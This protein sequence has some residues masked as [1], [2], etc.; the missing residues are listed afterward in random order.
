MHVII[1][2]MASM[3]RLQVLAA[4][5]AALAAPARAT[6][7]PKTSKVTI[8]TDPPGA[9][10]YFGLK[11]D[12][13]VC[14][15]PCTID[16]P[17]G[18]T[19]II[20][21]AENRRSIIENLV[22]PKRTARPLRV[23]YK[24]EPAIGALIVEGGDGATI[25]ID[26][27]DAGTAPGRIDGLLAGPHHVVV[28]RAGKVI[29]DDFL[30]IEAG[31]ETTAAV[32]SGKGGGEPAPAPREPDEPA[33]TRLDRPSASPVRRAGASVA[34]GVALDVGFRQFTFRNNQTPRTQRDDREGGQLMAGP[35]VEVWP[36]RLLGSDRLRGLA[37]YGRFEFGVNSQAVTV[38]DSATGMKLPTTLST[39][40]RSL[41]ASVHQRWTV[42][43]TA[44]VEVG[45]GYVQDRFQFKG[46][47]AE[48]AVVPDA[49]YKAVRIGGRLALLLGELEP[50]LTFESRIVLS[51]G[52]LGERY[53]LGTS[54]SGLRGT[55]GAALHFGSLQVRVEGGLTRYSWA[56][57][58]DAGDLTKADGGTDAIENVQFVLCYAR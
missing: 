42:A 28:E 17:I 7:A 46:S 39:S 32:G 22:V 38:L 11:E 13:E 26:D 41:E 49:S 50:Y 53:T 48:L 19:P 20:V 24:L 12:G 23:R 55:L 10:V 44:T 6:A 52:A 37:L 5:A 3:G 27:D 58:P 47:A 1:A 29:Y 33:V 36:T 31:H 25:K 9:K 21:E 16:A 2:A 15:T 45:A 34:V 54:V 35:I 14:T 18:E 30:E 57:R 8:E 40:W 4:C 51:G 43:N 56:F